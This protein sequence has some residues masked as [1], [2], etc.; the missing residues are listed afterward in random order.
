MRQSL[1]REQRSPRVGAAAGVRPFGSFLQ[2]RALLYGVRQP[3][4]R[5]SESLE[6]ATS[7][8]YSPTS[9]IPLSS[10]PT[11]SPR[12]NLPA[13][14]LTVNETRR[15]T[16][17]VVSASESA[18]PSPP[19]Q[20]ESPESYSPTHI[21]DLH[22]SYGPR[23]DS[24]SVVRFS[25][26]E[27]ASSSPS[28]TLSE[29]SYSPAYEGNYHHL[30]HEYRGENLSR[31]PL[32]D[33]TDIA[34]ANFD[35]ND[36]G[37]W[38]EYTDVDCFEADGEHIFMQEKRSTI[39]ASPALQAKKAAMGAK[40]AV[41]RSQPKSNKN[42]ANGRKKASTQKQAATKASTPKKRSRSSSSVSAREEP[43][44]KAMKQHATDTAT[45]LAIVKTED[46]SPPPFPPSLITNFSKE[47]IDLT[48]DDEDAPLKHVQFRAGAG[49]SGHANTSQEKS[50]APSR[51]ASKESNDVRQ[52]IKLDH[53]ETPAP[54]K[55]KTDLLPGFMGGAAAARSDNMNQPSSNTY[56]PNGNGSVNLPSG[57]MYQLNSNMN[58]PIGVEKPT[59]EH[60][61]IVSNVLQDRWSFDGLRSSANN[62]S[63]S[64]SQSEAIK[65]TAAWYIAHINEIKAE[66]AAAIDGLRDE[67]KA[68]L[69]FDKF[70][71][72]RSVSRRAEVQ[73]AHRVE[74][75]EKDDKI[76]YLNDLLNASEERYEA[77]QEEKKKQSAYHHAAHGKLRD[78]YK[79]LAHNT[80]TL[81]IEHE[82][83]KERYQASV[84][85]T[86]QSL[87][88]DDPTSRELR[89]E[90]EKLKLSLELE[91]EQNEI[92]KNAPKHASK[93]PRTPSPSAASS[94][95]Q[96]RDENLRKTFITVKRKYDN[97]HSTCENIST[98]TRGMD[99]SSFG[100]FGRYV[101]T[102]R[103]TMNDESAPSV[104][105][106]ATAND[107]R[108][109]S[110][111]A[112]GNKRQRVD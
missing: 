39:A 30:A 54:I 3:A 34:E 76:A 71:C 1:T 25:D 5:S 10:S 24:N 18:S 44:A 104:D 32:P 48:S 51:S 37:Y 88:L 29:E 11:L 82:D 55:P 57:N 60:N 14:L 68:L 77:L 99:L 96:T 61:P 49:F 58:Q 105:E 112:R 85:K 90:N 92:L 35:W 102:M 46:T 67:V 73:E 95:S 38:S 110:Y 47:I 23:G 106:G 28:R 6:R 84:Q 100:E 75:E 42:K 94:D 91:K 109:G 13:H 16:N 21:H 59:A 69:D 86:K 83:L 26:S 80:K 31:L 27:S 63:A 72:A 15:Y 36:S 70:S 12:S 2:S 17:S 101:K 56:R 4:S 79:K 98:A 78:E 9:P 22:S 45:K 41:S 53:T 111:S 19:A 20:P 74:M 97:L 40:L 66:H 43:A 81:R 64:D 87:K 33:D 52:T 89:A 50:A 107:I 65:K 7:L 8:P 103:S 93:I 108:S 62:A